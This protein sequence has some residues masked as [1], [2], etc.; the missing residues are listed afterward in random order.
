MGSARRGSNPLAVDLPPVLA[1]CLCHDGHPVARPRRTASPIRTATASSVVE[2]AS[3]CRPCRVP[4]LLAIIFIDV[5]PR[6]CSS[7]P[8]SRTPRTIIIPVAMALSHLD[9]PHPR[10]LQHVRLR[11]HQLKQIEAA[12]AAARRAADTGNGKAKAKGGGVLP[13]CPWYDSGCQREFRGP[14]GLMDKALVFGT[15]DCRFE[16]CQ[17][18]TPLSWLSDADVVRG[19]LGRCVA[20]ERL[21]PTQPHVRPP[22]T[23]GESTPLCNSSPRPS[24]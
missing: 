21:L 13:R 18:H 23:L 15:K 4:P 2:C 24:E 20:V 3:L 10:H 7:W 8:S 5:A 22:T 14:C 12:Q 19:G 1:G 11:R 17:G 16:S 6:S 9:P